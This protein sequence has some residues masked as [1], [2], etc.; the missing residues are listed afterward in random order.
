M[1]DVTTGV[2]PEKAFEYLDRLRESGVTNMWGAAEFVQSRFACSNEIAKK[3][4]FAWMDTFDGTTSV[5]DRVTQAQDKG[6]L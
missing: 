3:F 1:P 4:L 2:E 6:K 5:E